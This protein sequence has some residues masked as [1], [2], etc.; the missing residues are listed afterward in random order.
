MG[1]ELSLCA[2]Y[3]SKGSQAQCFSSVQQM[4]NI[5]IIMIPISHRRKQRLRKIR[6]YP[7]DHAIDI[8]QALSN[9][10]T[11][12]TVL[13]QYTV[14]LPQFAFPPCVLMKEIL[15][16]TE[17][18]WR[19][20]FFIS[21]LCILTYWPESLH[22]AK[23]LRERLR[24]LWDKWYYTRN[25]MKWKNVKRKKVDIK[26]LQMWKIMLPSLVYYIPGIFWITFLY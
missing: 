24:V 2:R 22:T 15:H 8:N 1:I 4:C 13:D 18:Q 6:K 10:S 3:Y 7:P 17:V 16:S 19:H 5:G 25:T 23:T 21:M 20:S 12:R 26:T 14:W 9:S 11:L